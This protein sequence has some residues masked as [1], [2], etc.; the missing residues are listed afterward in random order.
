M[1]L[2]LGGADPAEAARVQLTVLL[3][4]LGVEVVAAVACA[5]L[6]ARA[7]ESPG[8]RLRLAGSPAR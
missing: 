7:C 4:L 3:A 1:G 8:Q 6:V 2:V 5:V